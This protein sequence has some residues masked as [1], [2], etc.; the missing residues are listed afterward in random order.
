[1]DLTGA[2]ALGIFLLTLVASIRGWIP[3]RVLPIQSALLAASAL[4]A[5]VGILSGAPLNWGDLISYTSIHPVTATIAGF[6]FAGALRAAGGFEAA[7]SLVSRVMRLKYGSPFAVMLL[8]NLPTIFAMPCGRIWV[9][10][11]LPVTILLGEE[12]ARKNKDRAVPA[13]LVFGLVINAAAS[14]GPSLIGGIG[15]LGEGMGRYPAGSFSNP[16]SIAIVIISAL[17]MLFV[18]YFYREKAPLPV[19]VS[20]DA[21]NRPV[22][23]HGFFSLIIFIIVLGATV[24]FEPPV[25]LQTILVGLTIV[26]MLVEG[27]SINDLVGGIMLHPL[28]AMLSGFIAAGVLGAFGGFTVL[29]GLLDFAASSTPLGYAGVAV[30]LAYLPIIFPMPC[31][32]ILAVSLIPAVLMFGERLAEATAVPSVQPA[33]LIAF[34][35]CAAASCGPSPLGGIGSLGR[36][37]LRLKNFNDGLP[38]VLAILIG[39]PVA[40]LIVVGVGVHATGVS[41]RMGLMAL[42]AGVCSAAAI[43]A[44]L[45]FRFYNPGGIAAGAAVA[46]LLMVF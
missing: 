31:G 5:L 27:V 42:A 35:L 34:I 46:A 21:E 1:M 43:N 30:L 19:R 3:Q 25:P 45:G 14:C 20:A 26:V 18:K 38:Q 16:Q 32:R 28:T 44:V 22:P 7:A 11:L 24:A 13:M 41:L 4:I 10:P 33:L 23:E 12:I 15:A 2:I 40:A 9:A 39:V 37:G 8:V 6:V 29:V 17:V 36:G